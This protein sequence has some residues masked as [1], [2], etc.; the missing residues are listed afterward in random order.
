MM[1]APTRKNCLLIASLSVGALILLA[2]LYA[3][4]PRRADLTAFDAGA[5][6]RA[7]TQMWRH[8]YEKRYPAL[9]VDLYGVA[10]SQHG[11]SPLDSMRLSFLAA[12]AASRF[13][14]SHSRRQANAALPDLVAYYGI[15]ARAAPVP[16]DIVQAARTELDWWQAR[17]EN[18]GPD[19]YGLSVARVSSLL[20]GVDGPEIRQAGILRAQA[21][22]YRDAHDRD[23]TGADWDE[24]A[25]RLAASYRLLK[26][27]IAAKPH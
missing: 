17:R 23:M 6:A 5:M 15:L 12:R 25:R 24:I 20:Y 3:C 16:V 27:A 21:M 22:A 9:F 13:Q 19:R 11:F 2:A 26:Q 7:E 1:A 18:V 14:P 10:R 8:Y 4:Y